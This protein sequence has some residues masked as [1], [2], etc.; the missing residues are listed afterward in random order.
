MSMA[1]EDSN[2]LVARIPLGELGINTGEVIHLGALYTP[3]GEP[4][5]NEDIRLIESDPRF[6][7]LTMFEITPGE[8]GQ[9]QWHLCEHGDRTRHTNGRWYNVYDNEAE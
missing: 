8:D 2:F 6:D 5:R 4:I 7:R 9:N 1:P 3:D